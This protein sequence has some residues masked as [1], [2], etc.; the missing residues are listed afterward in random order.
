MKDDATFMHIVDHGPHST[1]NT[2]L[3]GFYRYSKNKKHEGVNLLRKN[4]IKDILVDSG[5]S[6][7]IDYVYRKETV[8]I[9]K[10]HNSWAYFDIE[11][12]E[13]KTVFYVST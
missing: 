3:M 7:F 12:L 5:F 11:D 2:S 13:A 8:D 1:F 10:I 6:N 9:K 4:E